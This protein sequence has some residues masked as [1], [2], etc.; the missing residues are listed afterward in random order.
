MVYAPDWQA[1]AHDVL[2]PL[3]EYNLRGL[4]E[5]RCPECG[6]RFHWVD[7][8]D[9][10]TRVHPF[11]FEHHPERNVR[12]FFRTLWGTLWPNKFWSS[13]SPS[14]PSPPGRLAAYWVLS[15]MLAFLAVLGQW[16]RASVARWKNYNDIWRAAKAGWEFDVG[17]DLV[18]YCAIFWLL[19]PWLTLVV[20]LIFRASM[21]RAKVKS[22]HI[23]RCLVYSFDI[24]AWIGLLV[25]AASILQIWVD[26]P[27]F[28]LRESVQIGIGGAI[29]LIVT[30]RLWRAYQL[31][32]RFDH[33][34]WVVLASQVIIFL[35]LA[36]LAVLWV[37]VFRPQERISY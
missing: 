9:P 19:W 15:S 31:Y 11:L 6:Y 27:L 23:D 5:A 30:L 28:D 32:L 16:V 13:L 26:G 1:I 35:F 18:W 8:V 29:V 3:C 7:V 37:Y 33:A 4:G 36:N 34:V 24:G 22:H 21:R 17:L 25:A 14:Q 10:K 2:C 20:L 12:S